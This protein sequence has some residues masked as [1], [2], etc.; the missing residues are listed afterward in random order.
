MGGIRPC[1]GAGADE[2]LGVG[3]YGT[4]QPVGVGFGPHHHE[5][6]LCRDADVTCGCGQRHSIQR[7]IAVQGGQLGLIVHGDAGILCQTVSEIGGH[8]GRQ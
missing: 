3:H 6:G 2:T 1:D 4:C 7:V 5:D 8:G